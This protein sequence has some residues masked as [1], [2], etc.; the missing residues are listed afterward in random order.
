VELADLGGG[1]G[2][3]GAPTTFIDDERLL[4][5]APAA[6]VVGDVTAGRAALRRASKRAL[7]DW[8]IDDEVVAAV[9]ADAAEAGVPTARWRPADAM[10]VDA[11]GADDEAASAGAGM[12][13]PLPLPPPL[14][15][16][17]RSETSEAVK[18]EDVAVVVAGLKRLAHDPPTT[19][20][21]P[22]PPAGPLTVAT[23]ATGITTAFTFC[24][25]C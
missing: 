13:L 8:K 16:K 5:C 3:I 25:C 2:A 10:T 7:Y 14:H 11:E 18:T 17:E 4:A 6:V 15:G 23:G 9:P 12:S 22:A 24:F 21:L 1:V 19:P 20:A